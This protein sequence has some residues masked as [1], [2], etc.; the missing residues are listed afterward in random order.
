HTIAHQHLTA[1][2]QPREHR[3]DIVD[4]DHAYIL[5]CRRDRAESAPNSKP[6]DLF[7]TVPMSG[8]PLTDPKTGDLPADLPHG[9]EVR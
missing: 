4:R 6:R 8:R 5:A 7:R 2:R 9:D 3:S 1:A